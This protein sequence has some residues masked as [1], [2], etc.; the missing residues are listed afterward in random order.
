MP[1]PMNASS[2]M[3][4]RCRTTILLLEMNAAIGLLLTL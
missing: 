2:R 1:V 3:Y 4:A